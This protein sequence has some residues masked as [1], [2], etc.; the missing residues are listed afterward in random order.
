LEALAKKRP[1]HPRLDEIIAWA[2]Q[3]SSPELRLAAIIGKIK[4]A[5]QTE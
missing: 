2:R 4:R 1:D 5:T 3:S